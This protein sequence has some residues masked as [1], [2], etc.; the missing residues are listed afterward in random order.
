MKERIIQFGTGNFLRGFADCFID[1]LNKNNLYDGKIVIVSPTDSKQINIINSQHGR[2]NL[3]LRGIEGG[4]EICERTEINA[5]SRGINPYSD[6]NAYLALAQNP[7]FRFIISNTTEAGIA[8]S[9]DD[10]LTDMPAKSFPAKLTQLLYERYKTGLKGFVIFACELIDN[11]AKELEKCVLK[12]SQHWCLGEDFCNWLKN[13]NK[14]CNTLVDRI[15]TGYPV[16]EA[17][18]FCS[19]IG[20]DDKLLDT[21]EPYHLWVI[22]GDYESELPLKKAGV[23][24]IWTDDVSLYKKM[25]VRILNGSHTSFV[26]PSLLCGVQTVG[27]SL[28]DNQLK[29]FLN[30]CLYDYILPTLGRTDDNIKFSDAVL[31]RFAN[32]YLRHMWQSISLN[33]V[34][35]FTARVLPTV[36]DYV[37]KNNA[38]PKPLVFSLACLIEYYKTNDVQDDKYSYD[39]IRE[40]CISAILSNK[41]LWSRDLS[42]MLELV[43]ECIDRIHNDGIRETIKWSIS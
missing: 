6:F 14:F 30:V 12:Y 3:Y 9:A 2:Y 4:K 21:A 10:K 7:D 23:N 32:P 27:E 19:E 39:F 42:N 31:E 11:N 1:R 34:S 29:E 16:D 37:D 5:I 13:E 15:V 18:Q 28:K 41:E 26:F 35:K 38:L 33:S 20:Y 36:S 24:V 40:N 22:E 8:F 25:K 43:S 17:E